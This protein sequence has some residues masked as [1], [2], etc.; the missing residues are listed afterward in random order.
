VDQRVG[1]H[2]ANYDRPELAQTVSLE[3]AGRHGVAGF[4]W[5][6]GTGRAP[7]RASRTSD[8][9][10]SFMP[11]V[12][13]SQAPPEPGAHGRIADGTLRIQPTWNVPSGYF[14]RT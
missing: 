5:S 6:G 1:A 10:I 12:A 14:M 8:F 2:T 4:R 9:D 11:I 13:V 3:A 7:A